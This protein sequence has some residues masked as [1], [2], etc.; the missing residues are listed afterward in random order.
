MKWP[1]EEVVS[2]S[3]TVAAA[4]ERRR[5]CSEEQRLRALALVDGGY[6]WAQAAREVGVTKA[7]IGTWIRRRRQLAGAG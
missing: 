7:T 5:G 1:P 2:A 4:G 3:N 6:S